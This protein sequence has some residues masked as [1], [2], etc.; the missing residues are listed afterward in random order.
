MADPHFFHNAGPFRL[1]EL[2][3][4]VGGI[5]SE[6]ANPN[7][8]IHDVASLEASDHTQVSFLDNKKYLSD[9]EITKAGVCIVDPKFSSKKPNNTALIL[10]SKPYKA[11]ALIAQKFYPKPQHNTSS[12]HVSAV[13]DDCAQIGDKCHISAGVYIGKN[14]VIGD[15]CVIEPNA[16]IGDGVKVGSNTLLG[17]NSSLEYCLLGDNCQIHAGVRIGNRGFGFAMEP[18][19]YIDVPQLGRVIIG[20]DVEVGANSCIDRGA[21]PDTIIGD[22]TKIDNLV[23][24]GHNVKMG[25]QCVVVAQSGIAGSA[26][27]D[28]YVVMGAQSGVAGH[29][30]MGAGVQIAGRAAV[31]KDVEA[32][33]VV[34]GTPAMPIKDFFRLVAMWKKQLNTKKG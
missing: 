9:F 11:Y 18:D 27:L 6:G 5:L 2:C 26:T 14:V 32:G 12:I 33:Q 28:D 4:L 34:A 31:I 29:I 24:I 1:S 16:V 15:G 19:G 3:D 7:L 13:I 23:Q 8:L 10:T 25:K 22:G 17:A 21:G 30:S 20:N